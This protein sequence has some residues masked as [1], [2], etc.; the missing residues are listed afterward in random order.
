MTNRVDHVTARGTLDS[1]G[2]PE[3]A[4][5]FLPDLSSSG[6]AEELRP[7]ERFQVF[8]GCRCP[9]LQLESTSFSPRA[10]RCRQKGV[11][12]QLT[13]MASRSV[14][15]PTKP[16]LGEQSR[17]AMRRKRRRSSII[18]TQYLRFTCSIRRILPLLNITSIASW[19]TRTIQQGGSTLLTR[20]ECW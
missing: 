14:A 4:W 19:A 17:Y 18:G 11:H 10:R 9:R 1:T 8:L 3:S 12:D 6:A 16:S 20:D 13:L 5:D 7:R 2:L 15:K